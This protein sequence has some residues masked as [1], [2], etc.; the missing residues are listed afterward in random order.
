MF[1]MALFGLWF[2]SNASSVPVNLSMQ[3]RSPAV[4]REIASIQD[5]K[6]QA[7]VTAQHVLDQAT[8]DMSAQPDPKFATI[9]VDCQSRI[10]QTLQSVAR[11]VRIKIKPCHGSMAQLEG[12]RVVNLANGN[13]GTLFQL[14]NG[15]ITTDY[16]HLVRGQNQLKIR[17]K[18]ANG[19]T[20]AS[21]LT[22]VRSKNRS[23]GHS[24]TSGS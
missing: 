1:L 18:A 22:I 16:I 5:V 2:W 9:S 24:P 20:Y 21:D 13:E 19:H 23:V 17:L 4:V 12:S 15:E 3:G 6:E 7:G 11:L 10:A 8:A 14:D